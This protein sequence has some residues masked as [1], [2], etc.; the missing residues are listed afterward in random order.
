MQ[1]EQRI[2]DR[3]GKYRVHRVLGRG[4][5]GVVYKCTDNIGR[6]M[7]IKTLKRSLVPVEHLRER[8][9]HEARALARL[10]QHVNIVTVFEMD[11]FEGIP[12]IAMPLLQ[13]NDLGKLLKSNRLDFTFKVRLEIARQIAQGLEY[14]HQRGVIHR[15]IKPSNIQVLPDNTVKILD[16]G[17]ARLED[18]TLTKAGTR[19]GTPLY[20]SPEQTL[21]ERV[22]IRSDIW[23]LGVVL[24]ELMTNRSPFFAN[25]YAAILYKIVHENPPP[26]TELFNHAPAPDLLTRLVQKCL[27]K[28]PEQRPIS[29]EEVWYVLGETLERQRRKGFYEELTEPIAQA[30]LARAR[31]L[32]SDGRVR[33]ATALLDRLD[34]LSGPI[35][36]E[37]EALR[38][39]CDCVLRVQKLLHTASDCIVSREWDTAEKLASEAQEIKPDSRQ[40]REMF[41]QI[42]DGRSLEQHVRAAQRHLEAG[43]YEEAREQASAALSISSTDTVAHLVFARAEMELERAQQRDAE[44]ERAQQLLEAG[45]YDAAIAMA[46]DI[47]AVSPA[48]DRTLKLLQSAERQ[49]AEEEQKAADSAIAELSEPET[50]E[51]TGVR[52]DS[53]ALETGDVASDPEALEPDAGPSDPGA[54][55]QEAAPP[56]PGSPEIGTAVPVGE[57]SGLVIETSDVDAG[58]TDFELDPAPGFETLEHAT[59]T[60]LATAGFDEDIEDKTVL[61][62]G[63]VVLPRAVG[64]DF[65]TF[66]ANDLTPDRI[67][68][69]HDRPRRRRIGILIPV[70]GAALGLA[71]AAFWVFREPGSR[72]NGQQPLLDGRSARIVVRSRP[73]AL[74]FDLLAAGG[75]L[76]DPEQFCNS[77]ATPA[78]C[79]LE[80][81][82]YTVVI[83][84][85]PK[86][87]RED[88]VVV[89][90]SEPTFLSFSFE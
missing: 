16:F 7:A 90:G 35:A 54:L 65:D 84:N 34:G 11:V 55:E 63:T 15:D 50:V 61:D 85:G 74:E 4:A 5:M 49:L 82:S 33:V 8:L 36:A 14:A 6:W 17:I 75:T 52:D 20:M 44:L 53:E 78:N 64:Q 51:P 72:G 62:D 42:Q 39:E 10:D 18:S 37:V 21:G 70:I 31:E 1:E 28:A 30:R 22:D 27:A 56:S 32:F 89:A 69:D 79:D 24:F 60:T 41:R 58:D 38:E 47:L 76:L 13:G 86:S 26:I 88:I 3:I 43:E 80:P 9:E 81:G 66:A 29:C 40:V 48:D 87:K 67:S 71:F 59:P 68:S 12:Y 73:G 45:A 46:E 2:P 23:S 19:M 83:R 57:S 77:G 25:D